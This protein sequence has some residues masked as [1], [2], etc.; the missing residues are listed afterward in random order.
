MFDVLERAGCARCLLIADPASGLQAFIALHD[1]T[2]GPAAGGVRTSAYPSLDA[3]LADASQLAAAMTM[4]SALAGL[5]AGGGK[6]VVLDHRG[7][8][9]AAAFA[10]LG[11]EVQMLGGIFR[12]GADLGT[13]AA[14]VQAMAAHTEYVHTDESSLAAAVGRGVVACVGACASAVGRTSIEGLR[15]AVQGAGAIGAAVASALSAAGAIILIADIDPD[16]AQAVASAGGATVVPPGEILTAD[17]D[18][19]APCAIGGVLTPEVARSIRAWAVCGAANNILA[20]RGA[21]EVLRARAILHVPDPVASA[22]AV[23]DGLGAS[24]MALPDRGPM[25]DRL[26]DITST[27]LAEATATGALSIDV[28]AALATARLEE[29][30]AARVR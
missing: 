30:R 29:A 20:D 26:G 7:L 24:L 23:I 18:V 4:K 5:P 12:T 21:A 17:V 1:L 25:I 16:R 27:I 19:L 11:K 28:A 8:D 13:T 9:R 14:D 6:A 22:G 3:A 10:R 15:V 2:L